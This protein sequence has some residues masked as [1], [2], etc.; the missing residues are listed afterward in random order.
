MW[1][2][3]VVTCLAVIASSIILW[4]LF[5][6]H[7]QKYIVYVYNIE[8]PSTVANNVRLGAVSKIPKVIVQN[9]KRR[10]IPQ[11]LMNSIQKLQKHAPNYA[12]NFYDDDESREYIAEHYPTALESFDT[13]IPGA[14]RSDL[15]R[16]VRLYSEGGVYFDAPFNP[17]S[18]ELVLDDVLKPQYDFVSVN[19]RGYGLFNAFIASVPKHPILKHAIETIIDNV[20]H[21]KYGAQPLCITGPTIYHKIFENLYGARIKEGEFDN[22][23]IKMFMHKHEYIV[24]G[25]NILYNCR[26]PQYNLDR[27]T[28]WSDTPHYTLLWMLGN[29]FDHQRPQSS[30]GTLLWSVGIHSLARNQGIFCVIKDEE[31]GNPDSN[32]ALINGDDNTFPSDF[33]SKTIVKLYQNY[34]KLYVQNLDRSKLTPEQSRKTIA[35]PIG[36]DFHTLQNRKNMWGYSRILPWREQEASLL[37][38]RQNALPLKQRRNKI[39]ATWTQSSKTSA[40]HVL[41]K[42]RP[43]LFKELT[44]NP[45]AEVALGQR[46]KVWKAMSQTA[47]VYSPIGDGYDCH[48]TWEALCL[49]C[50]VI[51]QRNP[52]LEEFADDYPIVFHDNPGKIVQADLDRWLEEYDSTPLSKLKIGHFFKK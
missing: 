13:L 25:S 8:Q 16:I 11:N 27:V 22:G 19:D 10:Y 26:Y 20:S 14:Y 38:L 32:L 51:A 6:S 43:K 50:I 48:R 45:L 28:Y 36:L 33:A 29:V 49:G 30:P 1:F 18:S 15:F 34:D 42:S 2:L 9:H 39:L 17:H 3:I 46:D 4:Q 40:R 31:S 21:R 23:R 47:F 24:D 35:V 44:S 7:Q 52:T 12:Y 41:Y 37:D 5:K